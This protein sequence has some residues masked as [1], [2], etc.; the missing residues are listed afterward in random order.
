L[1]TLK[2]TSGSTLDY[3]EIKFHV[4]LSD[5]FQSFRYLW[6]KIIGSIVA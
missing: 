5:A 4:V 1:T 2:I 3:K 6:K